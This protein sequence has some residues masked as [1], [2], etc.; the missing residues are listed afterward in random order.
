MEQHINKIN[1]TT[2]DYRGNK[3]VLNQRVIEGVTSGYDLSTDLQL[4][5]N[6]SKTIVIN[7]VLGGKI[8]LPN[9]LTLISGW[10]ITIINESTDEDCGIY[11]YNSDSL[12]TSVA[13]NKMT[14]IIFLGTENDLDEQGKWKVVILSESVINDTD[15]YTTNIYST[16]KID[17]TDLG[18]SF[19]YNTILAKINKDTPIKS[20]Y[21]KTNEQFDGVNVNLNV[22]LL[23]NLSYFYDNLSL[24]SNLVQRDLFNE[25]IDPSSDQLI[26][27]N[28]VIP[29]ATT[30]NWTAITSDIAETVTSLQFNGANY[31]LQADN[32]LYVTNTLSAN[33]T[34]QTKLISDFGFDSYSEYSLQYEQQIGLFYFFG[35]KDNKICYTA[36][37][38]GLIWSSELIQN[39]EIDIDNIKY[40]TKIYNETNDKWFITATKDNNSYIIYIDDI[41]IPSTWSRYELKY[42]D[43]FI[44]N[45]NN[46]SCDFSNLVINTN[47]NTYYSSDNGVTLN[48]LETYS[49]SEI[50]KFKYINNR[51]IRFIY[52]DANSN[53]FKYIFEFD[54]NINNWETKVLPDNI[55]SDTN[56]MLDINYSDGIWSI[57]RAYQSLE[58]QN[59]DLII[60]TDFFN[61]ILAINTADFNGKELTC[62]NGNGSKGY[63]LAGED[64]K[65]SYSNVSSS[66]TSLTQ[67][68][69]EVIIE[70]A[71]HINPV[72]L[73]NPI[74]QGQI[75]PLG[76]VINYPFARTLP[77]GYIRLDGSKIKN[78]K[79]DFPEFYQ[80]L[81][82][83]PQMVYGQMSIS[84][85]YDYRS[86]DG[87]DGS[88]YDI[89]QDTGNNSQW[90]QL[91]ANNDGNFPKFVWVD[92]QHNDIRCPVINCFIRGFVGDITSNFAKYYNDGLPNITGSPILGESGN[93]W[94][95]M[96]PVE[97]AIYRASTGE[98]KYAGASD[99]DNDYL[100]FDASRSN[101]IYGRTNEV[102]P[103]NIT[104]PYIM[105]YYH[106]IQNTGTYNLQ[107]MGKLI[108]KLDAD[109]ILAQNTV[110]DI[111]RKVPAGTIVPYGGNDLPLGWLW[112]NGGSYLRSTYVDLFDKIGIIYGAADDEHFYVPDISDNRFI[113]GTNNNENSKVNAGIPNIA[114]IVATEYMS[115]NWGAFQPRISVGSIGNSGEATQSF[116]NFNASD[117]ECGTQKLTATN[118]PRSSGNEPSVTYQNNVYGKSNTVQP[119]SIRLRYIIKY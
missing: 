52:N 36:S 88:Y 93:S 24:N 71:D 46:I 63:L 44:E 115:I 15:I 114:G 39:D 19:T 59:F 41:T 72:N 74:I 90:K 13:K 65:L 48:L 47:T 61:T 45:I 55:N 50:Y 2:R 4:E 96:P 1:A 18:A 113:E 64:G 51:W 76:T 60:S 100:A 14:E 69:V 5:E 57:F 29:G 117:G 108:E 70:Y 62:I 103:K 11:Y 95:R 99:H 20:I 42:N 89:S 31:V 38:D 53:S 17:Y 92:A 119:K 12:F 112:C 66:F 98:N 109:I 22:G 43:T 104:Y 111:T 94:S 49:N 16:T 26:I 37:Q 75:M 3:S 56:Y 116:A 86:D 35:V 102:R 78:V 82:E 34:F 85:E 7:N 84:G 118:N 8:F 32:T 107:T 81:L 28:F 97:G 106:A 21:I 87:F 40:I 73:L 6:I 110:N 23:N 58:E 9:A 77:A 30:N 10:K 67:G 101:S 33:I 105:S 27:G 91:V 54:S 25:V 79:N 68:S 80:L 83:N